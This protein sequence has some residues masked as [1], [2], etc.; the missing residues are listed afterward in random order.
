MESLNGILSLTSFPF[1]ELYFGFKP[2]M[3]R[4][5][6]KNEVFLSCTVGTI[7]CGS[8]TDHV[9]HELTE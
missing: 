7:N 5:L 3:L 1:S 8:K 9:V 2:Y 6:D 4:V